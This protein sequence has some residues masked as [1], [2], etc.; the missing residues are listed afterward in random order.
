[1]SV[2]LVLNCCRKCWVKMGASVSI[3]LLLCIVAH[4]VSSAADARACS[5]LFLSL[6]PPTLYP[7]LHAKSSQTKCQEEISEYK[8]VV[9]MSVPNLLQQIAMQATAANMEKLAN[10]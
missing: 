3:S 2:L 10:S 8:R 9:I 5:A 4:G 1:M 7:N 6:E